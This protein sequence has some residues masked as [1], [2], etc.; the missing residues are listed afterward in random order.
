MSEARQTEIQ[1]AMLELLED[2]K[3]L[4]TTIAANTAPAE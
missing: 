4:L 2:I 1:E 3:D